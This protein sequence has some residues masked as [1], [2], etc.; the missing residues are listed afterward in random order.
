M[1]VGRRGGIR[2]TWRFGQS[3]RVCLHSKGGL[4]NCR[5]RQE[6]ENWLYEIRE[7]RRSHMLVREPEPLRD[8]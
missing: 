5:A 6:E 8:L 1:E 3:R 7:G 2:E 4:L